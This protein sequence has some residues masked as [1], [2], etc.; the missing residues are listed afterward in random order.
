MQSITFTTLGEL[1]KAKREERNL[2]IS[3]LA[4]VTGIS[5]GVI[6][7]IE[8]GETRRPELRT[9]NAIAEGI[10]MPKRDMIKKYIVIEKR[11][12]VL[13]EILSQVI[14]SSDL[15][16]STEIATLFLQSPEED[17]YTSI[18]RLYNLAC[19]PILDECKSALFAVIVKYA[20]SHGIPH[21]LARGLL[22]TYLIERND[23]KRLKDTYTMG[24][25]IGH[26]VDFLSEE[27]KI[28]YYF[29]MAL[30]AYSLRKDDE[31]IKLCENGI[32]LEKKPTELMAR[33]YLAM[34]NT[35]VF[36]KNYDEVEKHLD[37]L[38]NFKYEFIFE[39]YLLTKAVL[40]VKKQQFEVAILD[41]SQ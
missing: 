33:A 25:E 4:R 7:K 26:Y 13:Y 39:A 20:R 2:S 18:E 8:T 16:L 23:Y 27:E 40:K 37:V 24:Q 17:T 30:H 28:T 32:K 15:E 34:I 41:L 12:E 9:I 11:T 36:M 3:E 14:D 38:V 1:L 10:E 22:Q 29:R 5:K 19:S 35:F 31:C 6:S 21:F